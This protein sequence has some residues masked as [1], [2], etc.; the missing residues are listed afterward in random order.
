MKLYA[1]LTNS[2][3]KKEGIGD[4][5]IIAIDI[6]VGNYFL[7]RLD[8]H[9]DDDGLFKLFDEDGKEIKC[10][11]PQIQLRETRQ[12]QQGEGCKTS[13]STSGISRW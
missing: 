2:K 12:K 8:V 11:D 5:E 4:N 13:P 9:Q 3:G 6:T 10:R 1:T 7:A